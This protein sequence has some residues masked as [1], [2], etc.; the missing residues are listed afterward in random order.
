MKDDN[1]IVNLR[2]AS[3]EDNGRNQ[4]LSSRNKTGVFGVQPHTPGKWKS[5]IK[6]NGKRKHLGVFDSFKKA[7][8]ARR[9]AE[10]EQGFH[11]NHGLDAETMDMLYG[12]PTKK[13]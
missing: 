4:K 2:E 6:K 3:H 11:E 1:R 5:W 13:K 10:K 7:V 9:Q 12:P 8:A